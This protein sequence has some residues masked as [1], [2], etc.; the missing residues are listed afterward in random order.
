[1]SESKTPIVD[2][3]VK[4]RYEY[5]DWGAPDKI[6][7]VFP[8]DARTLEILLAE[9]MGALEVAGK[10]YRLEEAV[11]EANGFPKDAK[12]YEQRAVMC[13]TPVSRYRA[14]TGKERP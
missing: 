10:E 8:E 11:S 13:E 3:M 12:F 14:L 4:V 2:A 1:M 5:G 6:E 9:A 7:Y